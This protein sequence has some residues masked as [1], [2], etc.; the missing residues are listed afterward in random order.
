M[1][2]SSQLSVFA[3]FACSACILPR[4]TAADLI[5][6]ETKMN[7][8]DAAWTP[9]PTQILS[10]LE[11]FRPAGPRPLSRYGGLLEGRA[12]A[13]GFFRAERAGD[14]WWLID[15]EGHPYLGMGVVSVAPGTSPRTQ[16]AFADAF[17]STAAWADS[18]AARLRSW[19]FNSVGAWSSGQ[20]L[21]RSRTGMA[22]APNW[23]FM[24]S[25]GAER[26]GI[27]QQAGHAGY[28][29][30]AIFVFDPAFPE[31]C[32]RHARQLAAV[33]DDPWLL[34]HFSDNELPWPAD[35]LRKYLGLPAAEPG[36]QAAQKWLDARKGKASTA[37]DVTAADE[38]AFRSYQ[39]G[40]YFTIVAAAIRKFDPNHLFLGP[41]F[42]GRALG[43]SLVVKAAGKHLD[44]VAFNWY[45]SW[46]P[47]TVRM[48]NWARWAGKPF[49]ITE[50]YAK[51]ADAP[52]LANTSGAGWLVRTQKDRGHYYQNFALGLLRNKACVGWQWFKYQDNDPEDG[53]TDP[54]NRDSNK[55]ILDLR[56][57][58]YVDL[59]AAMRDLNVEAYSLVEFLD[60]KPV[61]GLRG[62][63]A[64]RRSPGAGAGVDALGRA[65]KG[66]GPAV[67]RA[68]SKGL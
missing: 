64:E 38:E 16:A 31:F 55:G 19:G 49:L 2:A 22:W 48:A 28:P 20:S 26:G 33:K 47:D 51:G 1:R 41:R 60:G 23:N 9:R 4:P 56:Y 10:R 5:Q 29:N 34:G 21:A 27:T 12:A 66:K 25:Y 45:H 8:A 65:G 3:V 50:W 15:P 67:R 43:D 42:H 39:A 7:P 62:A 46:T 14:R 6:V 40:T 35:A 44:V 54:S 18:T 52:G 11:G 59:V 57:S 24:S 32:D 68:F 17:G 30:D 13:T 63:P 36:R 58:P 53:S 37:A 61:S